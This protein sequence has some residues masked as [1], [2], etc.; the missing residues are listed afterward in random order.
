MIA[1]EASGDL[2]GAGLIRAARAQRADLRFEGIAGPLMQA[3]GCVAW[4]EAEELSVMGLFEVLRHLPRLRRIIRQTRE[5]LAADPPDLL[6]GVDAPDFT[7]RI[8][9][10]ARAR[11]IPTLHYV[12]PSVWAWRKGRVKTLRAACDRVLCLLPFEAQFLTAHGVRG[13]FVGH[14]LADELRGDVDADSARAALG[15]SAEKLVAVLPGSRGGEVTRLAP[16]FAQTAAW[17]AA[18]DPAVR[19]AIPLASAAVAAPVLAAFEAEGPPGRWHCFDGRAREVIAAA[20][21]VLVASGTATLETMLVNR[22]MVAAYR[23]APLTYLIARALR[24]VKVDYFSLP[25]LLA[26]RCLVPEFLQ[27]EVRPEALGGALLMYLDSPQ[28]RAVLAREFATLGKALRCNA[29]NRAAEELL[30]MLASR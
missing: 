17:L 6:V 9:R 13:S 3:E 4:R 23:F 11:G 10:F 14:P 28:Q 15:L 1:G 20:D 19:F 2:L 16:V 25:N 26:G 22:P 30:E 7:L 18:R 8:E 29:S 12:S 21:V 24:L 5:R 27:H